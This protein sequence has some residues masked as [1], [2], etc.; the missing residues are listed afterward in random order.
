MISEPFILDASGAALR[1]GGNGT[2][3]RLAPGVGPGGADTARA[4]S[5]PVL[6]TPVVRGAKGAPIIV[7]GGDSF[8]FDEPF[9]ALNIEGGPADS[10]WVLYTFR[11]REEGMVSNGKTRRTCA[12]TYSAVPTAAPSANGDGIRVGESTVGLNLAFYGT[13]TRT[14]TV[15]QRM[16]GGS[17]RSDSVNT[18]TP[19]GG[20]APDG[21]LLFREVLAG[22]EEVYLQASGSGLSAE[23]NAVEEVG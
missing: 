12:V 5:F 13:T 16:R 8:W 11:N 23:V 6:V 9:T 22:A 17:W 7:M 20:T 15:W 14:V 3:F 2:G 1:K 19:T 4:G 10:S 18:I 21:E